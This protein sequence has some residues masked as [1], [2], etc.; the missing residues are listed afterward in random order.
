MTG[1]SALA[2]HLDG[3]GQAL[4]SYRAQLA[5]IRTAYQRNHHTA[6]S[7]EN[8][9]SDRPFWQRRHTSLPHPAAPQHSIRKE[10]A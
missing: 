6:Y 4:E 7:L 3:D 10:L 8:R 2:A 9:W 5:A 1:A